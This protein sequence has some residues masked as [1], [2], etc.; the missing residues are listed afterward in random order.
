VDAHRVQALLLIISRA[1]LIPIPEEP[2]DEIPLSVS[3]RSMGDPWKRR[4]EL[5]GRMLS[6]GFPGGPPQDLGWTLETIRA[7]LRELDALRTSAY[8]EQQRLE[9]IEHEGREGRLRLGRAM[10]ALTAEVSKTREEAR[11]LRA[12]V[13]PLTEA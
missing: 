7:H 6:R 12:Q 5:F 11:A 1:L 2:V 9:A 4:V 10:E 8:D 3:P 13:V